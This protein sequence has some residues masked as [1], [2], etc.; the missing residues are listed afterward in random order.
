MLSDLSPTEGRLKEPAVFNRARRP[1]HGAGAA[2]L[3]QPLCGE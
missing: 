2:D 3:P 1:G